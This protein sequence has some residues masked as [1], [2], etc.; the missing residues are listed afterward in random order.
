MTTQI[1][2]L[3]KHR[4]PKSRV[5]SGRPRGEK[6][7]KESKIDDLELSSDKIIIEIPEV[8]GSINPSFLEEF[9]YHVV[10]KLGIEGFR[11]KF[12]FKSLGV[13]KIEPD[14]EDALDRIQK[15][16]NALVSN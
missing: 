7:R 6:V 4:T 8:I 12:E 15:R 14:L 1:I 11:E 3:E 2:N 5:F 13:Y 10:R 9:L 16:Q